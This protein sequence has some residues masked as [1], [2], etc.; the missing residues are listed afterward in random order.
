MTKAFVILLNIFYR[1]QKDQAWIIEDFSLELISGEVLLIEGSNG[2]GKTTLLKIIGGVIPEYR[3]GDF[4]GKRNWLD[5]NN[6]RVAAVF[7]GVDDAFIHSTPLQELTFT[8]ESIENDTSVIENQ[9]NE[10]IRKFSMQPYINRNIDQLSS[11]ERQMLNLAVAFI[12]RPALLLLDEPFAHLDQEHIS[13][14]QRHLSQSVSDFHSTV[15]VVDHQLETWKKMKPRRIHLKSTE[16]ILLHANQVQNKINTAKTPILSA[17]NLEFAYGNKKVIQDFNI[18]LRSGEIIAIEGENGSGKTTLMNLLIQSFKP[19]AGVIS[20]AKKLKMRMLTRPTI[21]NFFS[22]KIKDEFEI[23]G[24][25]SFHFL[26]PE[27]LINRFVFDLSSGELSKT[28]LEIHLQNNCDILILDEPFLHLDQK[29]KHRLMQIL[30]ELRNGGM[31]IIYTAH[32]NQNEPMIAD[33]R[34]SL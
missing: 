22:M 19:N 16:D 13:M 5:P 31:S 15:V 17:Q 27:H 20:L 25:D 11:G 34:L 3:G 26:L 1:Y 6:S 10:M 4:L 9:V 2:V 32:P 33:R 8:M 7:H 21:H 18:E 24:V 29:S 30:I 14:V 23:Q 12:Q 28:A